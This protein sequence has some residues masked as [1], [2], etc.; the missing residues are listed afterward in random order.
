MWTRSLCVISNEK[1][2]SHFGWGFFVSRAII[3]GISRSA[4]RR[5]RWAT[6][7]PGISRTL[8]NRAERRFVPAKGLALCRMHAA[9][10]SAKMASS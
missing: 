2:P 1:T 10:P 6:P 7:F 3:G 8:D 5:R 9:F 4:K